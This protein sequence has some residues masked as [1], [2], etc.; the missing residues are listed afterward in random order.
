MKIDDIIEASANVGVQTVGTR[1]FL[2]L[3][4]TWLPPLADEF[5]KHVTVEDKPGV[6]LAVTPLA[7]D[8]KDP[9][10]CLLVLKGKTILA[11]S[12]GVLRPTTSSVVLP[13][14][15]PEQLVH[16][17][18]RPKSW[19]Q[20]ERWVFD[21]MDPPMYAVEVFNDGNMKGAIELARMV[22]SGAVTVDE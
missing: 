8:A 15:R 17:E 5:A 22:A 20:P 4:Q 3:V 1:P 10:G 21:L 18:T 14:S 9:R 7:V 16:A 11:W 6:L 2:Q 13:I 19:K 12:A